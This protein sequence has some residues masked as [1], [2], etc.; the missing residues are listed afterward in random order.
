MKAVLEQTEAVKSD[1]DTFPVLEMTCA[2]CAVSVESTLKS[3]KGVRNAG[4]NFATQSAWVE[5]DHNIT[6]PSAMKA[7]IQSIGY[8]LVI[9]KSNSAELQEN[10]KQKHYKQIRNRTAW[11]FLFTI[12][13]VVISMFFMNM[14][15]AEY[16]EMFLSA[17]VVFWF[18][19]DFFIHAWKQARHKMV[20][21][22]TLVALST[23][24]AFLFSVIN[25]LF[26]EYWHSRGIHAPV[27]F[28]AAAVIMFFISLGK[29]LEAR[30]TAKTSSALKKLMGLQPK[31]VRVISDGV[32]EET[33]VTSLQVGDEIVVKPGDSVAVDGS[34]IDGSSYVN[35]S[36]ISGEPVPVLKKSGDRVFAGTINQ[37]GS[38]V[39]RAEKVGSDTVL[40]QIIRRVEF[41]QGSKAPV[42]KLVDKIAGVFVPVV[43]GIAVLTFAIWMIF[44]GD[45]ALS[46]ALLTSVSVLVIACPCALG[47]AT[48][49]AV[50]VGIGKGAEHNILIR[51]AESLELAHN[52]NVV[53]LDKTGTITE[54]KPILTELVWEADESVKMQLRDI[55]FSMELRSEHPLAEAVVAKLKTEQANELKIESFSSITGRG[56]EGKF[57]N[58]LYVLG[59]KQLME[60]RSIRISSNLLAE[61]LRLQDDAKTVGFF[62]NDTD[63]VAMFAIE[64][65]IKSTSRAGIERLQRKG[66][67]VYMVTGDNPETA[68]AVADKVGLKNYQANLLPEDKAE[69]IKKLQAAGKV[70]AMVG[71]GINDAQALAQ[72]DVSI[73]MGKGSDIAM[74]VARMTLTTSDLTVIS[75]A[76]NLSAKT[77]NGIRQ[78]LF[79]AFVY[80]I[81]GIPLAAGIL[82]PV[83]GFLLNPMI[84]SAA[85]ALSSVSVVMNSLR[86]RSVKI[87]N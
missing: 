27:Y 48:P 3:V 30:A 16:V 53:I 57:D 54:G 24:T 60:E 31:T 33:L 11:A 28:E 38:F 7:A 58:R 87:D 65:Q 4:V 63:A 14:P 15:Y 17:P 55:M 43:I 77:V 13:V 18:G 76:F 40:A 51:D 5:Y 35:E 39:F 41:A 84:A 81:I 68:K 1:K 56:V 75:K 36:M 61:A 64:D 86:L 20:N 37:K 8:D 32:E 10:E 74:E 85:M 21:M 45:D 67:D 46:H 34:V 83:N 29:L 19:K 78:N 80:N 79:W 44:G 70:V 22:D 25:T 59:N 62:A 69:F 73:A 52:V 26:P 49:T 71:D 72:A 82:F 6:S 47:L 23:G 50:M 12:P 9:E 42:Q 66:I 2:A